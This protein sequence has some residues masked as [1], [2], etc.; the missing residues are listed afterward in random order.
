MANKINLTS[1]LNQVELIAKEGSSVIIKFDGMRD[2][3]NFYT[4]VLSG[5]KL[6][7]DFFRKDGSDLSSLLY[8]MIC[9]YKNYF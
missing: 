1:Y 4:V 3:K 5:G 6:K 2:E 9:Y 8:E 7:S